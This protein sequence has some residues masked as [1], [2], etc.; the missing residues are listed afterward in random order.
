ML[1]SICE[2]SVRWGAWRGPAPLGLR[3]RVSLVPL[4]VSGCAWHGGRL[5]LSP[6]A[7]Q[8]PP[9]RGVK[10]PGT[11]QR[12]RVHG[13]WEVDE[14]RRCFGSTGGCESPQPG[15]ERGWGP[16][17]SPVPG[18]QGWGAFARV[19][20]G[21]W[22]P[23]HPP[24]LH[25]AGQSPPTPSTSQFAGCEP[26]LGEET[27]NLG[28]GLGLNWGFMGSFMFLIHCPPSGACVSLAGS[29]RALGRAGGCAR[30]SWDARCF[31]SSSSSSFPG[32]GELGGR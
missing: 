5:W 10:P 15:W 1:G 24:L 22:P 31:P 27:G 11:Q 21:A 7:R 19:V 16:V 3:G 29:D 6:E 9:G 32:L 30:G 17:C 4:G 23:L 20:G 2:A 25:P 8:V 12:G 26:Q 14:G 13:S 18:L 28:Q